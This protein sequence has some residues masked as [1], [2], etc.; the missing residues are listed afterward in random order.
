MLRVSVAL[1]LL[2]TACATAPSRPAAPIAFDHVWIVVKPGAP[3]RAVLERNGIH[4]APVV[5][6]HEGQGTAS[7]MAE[8]QNAF[9]ELLWPDDTVSV[10]PGSER[11]V[12]RFRSRMLWRTSGWSPFGFAFHYTG[13]SPSPV[14]LPSWKIAL[15]WMTPGSSIEMLTPRDDATSPSLSIHPRELPVPP[16][17][18]EREIRKRDGNA[19]AL[20]H[21]L[22]LKRVTAVRL[23]APPAY[24][25]IDAV[26]WLGDHNVLQLDR[27]SEWAVEL[28][29]DGASRGLT[30]DFRPD[31]PL[32]IRF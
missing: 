29:F 14:P 10:A 13:T 17:A 9:L 26:T 28:T 3:E 12:E 5:N 1:L 6:R 20:V 30:K 15:P 27:G 32:L 8:F 23:I 2:S 16:D 7:V 11:A 18:N 25:P 24:K 22:G 21:A 4:V 19:D 31:L